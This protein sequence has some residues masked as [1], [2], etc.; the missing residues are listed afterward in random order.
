MDFVRENLI[1]LKGVNVETVTATVYMTPKSAPFQLLTPSGG[2]IKVLLFALPPPGGKPDGRPFIIANATGS[3]QN[4]SVKDSTDSTT[5][6]TLTPGTWAQII[7]GE[8]D[9][10]VLAAGQLLPGTVGSGGLDM[11]GAELILDADGN[12]SLTADTD[13]QIDVRINGADDFRF[14]ANIFR[15]LAGSSIEADTIN[16]TTSAAGVTIDGV[17]LKDG[18]N[19]GTL[20]SGNV[21]LSSEQTGTGSEQ[22]IAHGLGAVPALVFVVASNLSG[23]PYVISYGTHDGTNCKV[24]A[25]T[26]EKYRVVAFK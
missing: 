9:W 24:T 11:D 18:V 20:H 14:I 25:T 3:G 15:A 21:F 17:L 22:S 16:E 2:T 6:V 19:R 8:G 4:L 13:N 10:R 1:Y 5:Y 12:T 23:G 26:G 7:S